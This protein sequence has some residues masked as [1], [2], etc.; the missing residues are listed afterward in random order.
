MCG[1]ACFALKHHRRSISHF[2]RFSGVGGSMHG[3]PLDGLLEYVCAMLQ[4]NFPPTQVTQVAEDCCAFEGP[5]SEGWVMLVKVLAEM[6]DAEN[7]IEQAAEEEKGPIRAFCRIQSLS[8]E[9]EGSRG[10][11]I[12]Y[13]RCPLEA[14]LWG[15]VPPSK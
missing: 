5:F 7:A 11:A 12:P 13:I 9:G 14:F 1:D 4:D 10:D 15:R 6:V 8:Q 2:Q 3:I